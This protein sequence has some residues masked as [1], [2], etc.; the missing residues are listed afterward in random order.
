MDWEGWVDVGEV[1]ESGMLTRLVLSDVWTVVVIRGA[2][3]AIVIGSV[4]V[5]A[6]ALDWETREVV[7]E[8]FGRG[9]IG[10]K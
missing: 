6:V 1:G 3:V 9:G 8:L 10:G 2:A 4:V 7:D 5:E